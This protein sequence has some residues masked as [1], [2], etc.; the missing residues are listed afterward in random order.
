MRKPETRHYTEE[1]I[2]MFAIGEVPQ[3][4]AAAIAGHLQECAGCAGVSEEFRGLAESIS[5]WQLPEPGDAEVAAAKASVLAEFRRDRAFTPVEDTIPRKW[6]RSLIKIWDYALENPLP[7]IG[8]VV[9]G[10]AFASERTIDLFRLDRI[11]PATN[12]VFEILRQIF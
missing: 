1:E 11:L 7:T 10:L 12:E 9:V 5:A 8:Y 3:A 6:V 2:L 4:M